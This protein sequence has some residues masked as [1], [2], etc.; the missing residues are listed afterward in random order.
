[1]LIKRS[2]L[3][4]Y[5]HWPEGVVFMKG[6]PVTIHS[7]ALALWQDAWDFEQEHGEDKGHGWLLLH[8]LTKLA[9]YQKKEKKSFKSY[10]QVV[11]NTNLLVLLV[12]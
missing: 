10:Y 11:T 9:C 6:V 12:N 5:R 3:I 7:N 8:P 4:E 2:N 1:M